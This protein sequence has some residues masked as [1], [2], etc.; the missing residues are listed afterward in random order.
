MENSY[1]LDDECILKD[2]WLNEHGLLVWKHKTNQN[3]FLQRSYHWVD[4]ITML[5]ETEGRKIVY[6]QKFSTFDFTDWELMTM[7]EFVSVKSNF[8]EIYDK[9][10]G[11]IVPYYTSFT[12]SKL[13][14]EKGWT[15]RV[16]MVWLDV[17]DTQLLRSIDINLQLT[18]NEYNAPEHW[19]VVEWFDQEFSIDVE[20]RPIRYAGDEKTSFYQPT[21]N[22]SMIDLK[23]FNTKKE[24]FE[25]VFNHVLNNLI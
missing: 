18:D 20:S 3:L 1:Y 2:N 11:K 8:K 5:D 23:K 7:T 9:M 24:S 22:G 14:K 21:I 4:R 12:N 10:L 25:Y 13:L 16:P 19:M 15:Q 17:K 6:D